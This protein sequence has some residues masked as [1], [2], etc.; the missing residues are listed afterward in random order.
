MKIF[1]VLWL[2]PPLTITTS[3]R[4][5]FTTNHS[6]SQT[7]TKRGFNHNIWLFCYYRVL[8]FQCPHRG[9]PPLKSS[10]LVL[11][12][13]HFST[14]CLSHVLWSEARPQTSEVKLTYPCFLFWVAFCRA[15]EIVF[16]FFFLT[17]EALTRLCSR[18]DSRQ[19]N[20]MDTH[21]LGIDE[22][23]KNHKPFP[24]SYSHPASRK[25][26]AYLCVNCRPTF[27]VSMCFVCFSFVSE[28]SV[29]L[30]R[31]VPLTGGF[32]FIYFILILCLKLHPKRPEMLYM[33]KKQKGTLK[34]ELPRV[35]HRLSPERLLN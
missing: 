1:L 32:S 15:R 24:R 18:R 13:R 14:P 35:S 23:K 4:H 11:T 30:Q 12:P 27:S 8:L 28:F 6:C 22:K 16:N 7:Q 3:S 10:A 21:G 20:N 29:R 2:F 19:K 9:L 5:S 34:S 31:V 26:F 25:Y 17:N 33:F